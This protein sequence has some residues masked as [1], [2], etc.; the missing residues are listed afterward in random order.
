MYGVLYDDT[1]YDYMQHL[2][3]VGVQEDGVESILIEA[4]SASRKLITK[5]NKSISLRDLPSEV[6]ASP[7]ELPRNY[8]SE[9]AIPSSIAGFQPDMNPHL[10][11]ALEAL[12][13]DAFVDEE[14]HDDF[15]LELIADGERKSDEGIEF[16]FHD[17]PCREEMEEP[18]VAKDTQESWEARFERFKT[19]QQTAI[20][21]KSSGSVS[22]HRSEGGDTIG[23]LPEL[24]VIGGKRRRK[25]NSDAS[26]HSMSSSSLFRT[27]TLQTLDE[28]FDQ[29]SYS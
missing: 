26:G 13:D 4:P 6:L 1:E 15:F 25:G 19:A 12:D 24:S 21:A 5:G 10:R 17:D 11:Q 7:F 16:E 14:I 28:R 22:D 2:R 20:L 23:Q 9:E 29:V 3:Q 8:E 27:E 18:E